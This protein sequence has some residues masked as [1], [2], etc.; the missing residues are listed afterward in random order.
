MLGL[1]TTLKLESSFPC[2]SRAP[3]SECRVR[4]FAAPP[5]AAGNMRRFLSGSGFRRLSG[6]V[7]FARGRRGRRRDSAGKLVWAAQT[8]G[9]RCDAAGL[10]ATGFNPLNQASLESFFD[11]DFPKC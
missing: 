9:L 10:L 2:I 5:G 11:V 4:F 3:L 8:T 6:P 7:H 1:K